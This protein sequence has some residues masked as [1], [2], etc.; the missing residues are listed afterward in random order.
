MDGGAAARACVAARGGRAAPHQARAPPHRQEPLGAAAPSR[1]EAARVSRARLVAPAGGQHL[2]PRGRGGRAAARSLR[3]G[4]ASRALALAGAAGR[5]RRRR[6]RHARPRRLAAQVERRRRAV[7][8]RVVRAAGARAAMLRRGARRDGRCRWG[9]TQ[10]ALG[11]AR[12]CRP[13]AT[14]RGA[15]ATTW[16]CT[17]NMCSARTLHMHCTTLHV[18]CMHAAC[19]LH[20]HCSMLFTKALWPDLSLHHSNPHPSPSP[21]SPRCCGRTTA[22]PRA[23]Q[24]PCRPRRS[25]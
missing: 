10:L 16:A 25:T 14:D 3:G 8:A 23:A 12:G 1:T 7:A 21:S 18:H 9:G 22:P 11:G 6:R 13:R 19:T 5:R 4:L 24:T 20:A 15:L 17:C 2:R